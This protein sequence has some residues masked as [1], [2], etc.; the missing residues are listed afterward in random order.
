MQLVPM[1]IIHFNLIY[2]S[3]RDYTIYLLTIYLRCNELPVSLIPVKITSFGKWKKMF[4]KWC[5][6]YQC[7][8]MD[9]FMCNGN[10][11]LKSAVNACFLCRSLY[12]VTNRQFG[13]TTITLLFHIYSWGIPDARRSHSQT[14]EIKAKNKVLFV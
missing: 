7:S 9:L 8:I 12:S 11:R 10:K 6:P 3:F 14:E 1:T 2:T 5:T 13:P 4:H